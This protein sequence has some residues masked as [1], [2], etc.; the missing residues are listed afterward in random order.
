M[1]AGAALELLERIENDG[2]EPGVAPDGFG[3]GAEAVFVRGEVG[4]VAAGGG[5]DVVDQADALVEENALA[6]GL[7]QQER[8]AGRVGLCVHAADFGGAQLQERGDAVEVVL[9]D[10]DSQVAAAGGAGGAID[11][12]F[13]LGADDVEQ[14]RAGVVFFDEA[15]ELEVLR[16]LFVREPGEFGRVCD[17]GP[18]ILAPGGEGQPLFIR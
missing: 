9:A 14:F 7:G 3:A 13:D 17:H 11:G 18:R 1:E 2:A 8:A 5:A 6:G 4:E 12:G 16:F 15:P 10:F